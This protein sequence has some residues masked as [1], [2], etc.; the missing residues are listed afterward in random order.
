MLE[1][2]RLAVLGDERQPRRELVPVVLGDAF[3]RELFERSP[4]EPAEAGVVV[5]LERGPE[6]SAFREQ[7]GLR[8]MEEAREQLAARQVAGGP[9]QHHQVRSGGRH[10]ARRDVGRIRSHLFQ[11][12]VDRLTAGYRRATVR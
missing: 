9:E 5:L 10:E 7:V 12:D 2:R 8:E 4:G 11:H 3:V 1:R 6:D